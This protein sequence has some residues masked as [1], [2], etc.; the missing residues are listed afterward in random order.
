MKGFGGVGEPGTLAPSVELVG[1]GEGGGGGAE[2]GEKVWGGAAGEEVYR[3]GDV[4]GRTLVSTGADVSG[5]TRAVPVCAGDGGMGSAT[6]VERGVAAIADK[7]L[8]GGG[9]DGEVA[10]SA[11]GSFQKELARTGDRGGG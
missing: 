3:E 8:G 10:G 11:G 9:F 4:L 6:K 7:G 5:T 2:G 1:E